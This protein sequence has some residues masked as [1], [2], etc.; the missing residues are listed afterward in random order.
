V[1]LSDRAATQAAHFYTLADGWVIAHPDDL[2]MRHF[3]IEDEGYRPE[4]ADQILDR[5]RA[6][7]QAADA[8]TP[9]WDE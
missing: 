7:A 6:I 5:M 1:R 3:L 8:V 9:G 2:R 4:M